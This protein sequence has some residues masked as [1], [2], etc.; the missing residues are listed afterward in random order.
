[1]IRQAVRFV[2]IF[3]NLTWHSGFRTASVD[4][5]SYLAPRPNGWY[6]EGFRMPARREGRAW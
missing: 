2:L 1:M 5:V 4:L 6:R 3:R